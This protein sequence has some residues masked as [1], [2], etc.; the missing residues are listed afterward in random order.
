MGM[1][2]KKEGN[3]I[4]FT[5]DQQPY[6]LHAPLLAERVMRKGAMHTVLVGEREHQKTHTQPEIVVEE[7]KL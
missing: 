4:D 1:L 5:A 7:E 3:S 6:I 2:R